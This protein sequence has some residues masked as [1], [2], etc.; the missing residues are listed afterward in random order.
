MPDPKFSKAASNIDRVTGNVVVGLIV[1]RDGK[2]CNVHL[3]RG[4]GMA[5]LDESAV[6]SVQ[7]YKFKPARQN[8][9]PVAV[10]LNI[11][12][13]FDNTAIHGR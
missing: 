10:N 9:K 3:V 6:E 8:G 7:H 11:E 2:P 1:G 5:G 12:V 4:I 13:M